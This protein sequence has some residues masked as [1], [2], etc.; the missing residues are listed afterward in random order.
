FQISSNEMALEQFEIMKR[1][2]PDLTGFVRANVEGSATLHDAQAQLTSLKGNAAARDLHLEGRL[3]G[4]VQAIAQTQTSTLHLQVDS[5]FLKSKVTATGNWRLTAGYP[6]EATARFSPIS[7]AAVRTWLNGP[8]TPKGPNFDGVVEGTVSVAG[9]FGPATDNRQ[10][11]T[12]LTASATLSRLE[13]YPLE[14]G[15]QKAAD[16]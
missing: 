10:P 3:L 13:V 7:L 12:A 5:N 8:A 11:T 2:R 1:R 9:A 14:V 15:E 6:G 16:R 4:N